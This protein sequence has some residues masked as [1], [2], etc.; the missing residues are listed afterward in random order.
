MLRNLALTLLL[1]LGLV[2]CG[3]GS[4]PAAQGP[5]AEAAAEPG[6]DSG[7]PVEHEPCCCDYVLVLSKSPDSSATAQT[8]ELMSIGACEELAGS[9][10]DV[11]FSCVEG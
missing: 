5:A 3:G 9:C 8:F 4:K 11:E 1:T 2:A 6:V 10:T 7:T